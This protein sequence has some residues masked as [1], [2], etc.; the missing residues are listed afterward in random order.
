M[1]VKAVYDLDEKDLQGTILKDLK[2]VA[3]LLPQVSDAGGSML[4][5]IPV[6][7]CWLLMC[8][9]ALFIYKFIV[10]YI[11]MWL[12]EWIPGVLTK[13]KACYLRTC[14]EIVMNNAFQ[15]A[16]AKRVSS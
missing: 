10:Q 6:C 1:V 5:F 14:M 3:M 11:P 12:P 2:K 8:D 16:L 13:R 15:L 9:I 4:D 7:K